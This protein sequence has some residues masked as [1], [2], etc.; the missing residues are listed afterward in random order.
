[1][2]GYSALHILHHIPTIRQDPAEVR[3]MLHYLNLP[4]IHLHWSHIL[5]TQVVTAFVFGMLTVRPHRPVLLTNL[6]ATHSILPLEVAYSATSSANWDSV[7]L[8]SLSRDF[9][10]LSPISFLP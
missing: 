2:L 1:M 7:T 6:P 5:T 3:K 10:V 4:T 9:A 8:T